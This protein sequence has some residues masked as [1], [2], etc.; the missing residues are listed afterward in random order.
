VKGAPEYRIS[1]KLPASL[2]D[3]IGELVGLKHDHLIDNFT[4]RWIRSDVLSTYER[5]TAVFV[6][7]W[8]TPVK[9]KLVKISRTDLREYL[10]RFIRFKSF[11][12]PR[13]DRSIEPIPSPL[14]KK[15]ASRLA[16]DIIEVA[17]FYHLPLDLLLGIGAMENNFMNVPGD[18][19]NAIWKNRPDR[20]DIVLR[21]RRGKVLVRNDSQGVWQ[22]TRESLRYAHRLYLQDRRDYSALPERLRPA[23]ELDINNVPPEQLTTY[24]GLL[25][26]DLLERFHGDVKQ[27]AGAYNGGIAKPNERY[28]AGVEM[29]A[30]YARR[31]LQ[32]AA[33]HNSVTSGEVAASGLIAHPT[34]YR[35]R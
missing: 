10:R 32:N 34:E 18:L 3:G 14:S 1:L 31:I 25:L 28:A 5:D 12:D 13:I 20:G 8:T 27:A 6:D 11:T 29:V 35:H 7:T 4:W 9:S 23:K 24:A 26:R 30:T 17:D 22:V 2:V 33:A 21:R 16:A 15:D 19:H